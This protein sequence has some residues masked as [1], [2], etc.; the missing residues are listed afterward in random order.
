MNEIVCFGCLPLSALSQAVSTVCYL[1]NATEE[2]H[3][4]TWTI[5]RNLLGSQLGGSI[6]YV[7]RQ[8]L[9]DHI[10]DCSRLCGAVQLISLGL[11]GTSSVSSMSYLSRSILSVFLHCATRKETELVYAVV[12]AVKLMVDSQGYELDVDSWSDILHLVEIISKKDIPNCNQIPPVVARNN[13]LIY[14]FHDLLSLIEKLWDNQ[15]FQGDATKLFDIVQYV[16][17]YRPESSLILL[18]KYKTNNLKHGRNWFEE[19]NKIFDQFLN[20]SSMKPK[21]RCLAVEKVSKLFQENFYAYQK[22]ISPNFIIQTASN[23]ID[24][25][26]DEVR[27][28]LLCMLCQLYKLIETR[29]QVVKIFHQ[30]ITPNLR[31]DRVSTISLCVNL[32]TESTVEMNNSESFKFLISFIRSYYESNFLDDKLL[33]KDRIS[34]FSTLLLSGLHLEDFINTTNDVYFTKNSQSSYLYELFTCVNTCIN[35]ES[36]WL[37][38]TEVLKLLT[39]AF[40]E[41]FYIYDHLNTEIFELI[42]EDICKLFSSPSKF[43]VLTAV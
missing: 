11:W 35:S 29:H 20:S 37:V 33:F 23:L 34:A 22:E 17:S 10:E 42:I 1:Y 5:F 15:I 31:P 14:S 9:H 32:F 28:S 2:L 30:F 43:E 13:K 18:L 24:E 41:N 40:N 7:V 8:L 38:L 25:D 3:E 21:V 19:V 26:I 39:Q 6:A 36:N 12:E 4:I 27:D 16:V